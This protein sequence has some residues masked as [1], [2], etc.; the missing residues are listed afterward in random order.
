MSPPLRE[1]GSVGCTTQRSAPASAAAAR[2]S[3]RIRSRASSTTSSSRVTLYIAEAV[4]ILDGRGERS[5]PV[6]HQ[7]T[8]LGPPFAQ[9]P[10]WPALPRH[11]PPRLYVGHCPGDRDG[12]GLVIGP[13][14]RADQHMTQ[15]H[16][17]LA[18]A[19]SVLGDIG[20]DEPPGATGPGQH[21]VD[22]EYL[23]V[24]HV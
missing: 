16:T 8:D 22:D 13:D 3:T 23:A 15:R 19:R 2:S 4:D 17:P 1:P 9:A 18:R 7:F 10:V 21:P 24:S 12:V 11:L 6:V 14:G 20:V 5:G